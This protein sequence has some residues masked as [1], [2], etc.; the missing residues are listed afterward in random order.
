MNHTEQQYNSS[1]SEVLAR[2]R[3]LV[4]RS[5]RLASGCLWIEGI[6]HFVQAYDA[7]IS[8]ETVIYSRRLLKSDLVEMLIRPL[9]RLGVRRVRVSPEEFRSVCTAERASGVGAI[10]RQRWT[11]LESPTSPLPLCWLVIEELRSAGNLGTIL[12]TAE[13][14]GVGGIIFVGPACDP[15]SPSVIRASMGGVFHL[16]L[17]RATP[18]E[19]S[20]WVQRNDVRVV[21]LAPEAQM[22]WTELAVSKP[23]ALAIG[24]ERSGLSDHMRSLCDTMVRLPMVGR[25]DSLNVGVATGVMLYELVRRAQPGC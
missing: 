25:A 17:M 16:S 2:A 6:R 4:K 15:Y 3:S 12:R 7:E 24:E 14:T 1:V 22:L 18:E 23:V 20:L 21:G 5:E 13:A 19:L 11:P 9:V 10:A 8:F